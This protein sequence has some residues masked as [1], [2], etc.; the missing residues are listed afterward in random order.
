M[1]ICMAYCHYRNAEYL[2]FRGLPEDVFD[3]GASFLGVPSLHSGLPMPDCK[4]GGLILQDRVTMGTPLRDEP[5]EEE[6]CN[7]Q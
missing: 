5:F 7:I 3:C 4:D 2:R 1:P 6:I